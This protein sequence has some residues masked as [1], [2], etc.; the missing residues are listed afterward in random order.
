[1]EKVRPGMR[2]L[3]L[4]AEDE[5]DIGAGAEGVAS[6]TG[7]CT[8]PHRLRATCPVLW[9]R[10]LHVAD[11]DPVGAGLQPRAGLHQGSAHTPFREGRYRVYPG[12]YSLVIG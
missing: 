6:G 7:S 10:A 9:R 11:L 1:V 4:S 5:Q 12:R 2:M 3:P 8:P